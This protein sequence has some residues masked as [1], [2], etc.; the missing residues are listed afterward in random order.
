M[1]H[2][3]EVRYHAGFWEYKAFLVINSCDNPAFIL[4]IITEIIPKRKS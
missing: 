2:Y 1:R 3:D 4:D